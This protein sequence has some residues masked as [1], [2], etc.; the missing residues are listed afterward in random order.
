LGRLPRAGIVVNMDPVHG[1]Y[2]WAIKC[3]PASEDAKPLTGGDC[4]TPNPISSMYREDH[5][6]LS[7]GPLTGGDC[8]TLSPISS[9]FREDHGYLSNRL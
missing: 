7:D 9:M 8:N 4:N 1:G 6:Y 2:M 5:G 3:G